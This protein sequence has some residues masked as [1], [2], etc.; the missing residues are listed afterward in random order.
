MAELGLDLG[1]HFGWCI[2]TGQGE[3]QSGNERIGNGAKK[4][5]TV[6]K[7]QIEIIVESFD[8]DKIYYEKVHFSTNT[9]ATQAHGAYRS[10]V[11]LV[12]DEHNA[13]IEG[14]AVRTVKKSLTGRG[15]ASKHGMMVYAEKYVGYKIEDD[16]EAD[17]IG[18][19]HAGRGGRK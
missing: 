5:A 6:L 16:N 3:F 19:L 9:Y 12:A 7:E 2:R 1:Q 13:E 14:I 10:M 15:N 17:A 18:V 4:T 11:E 8:V